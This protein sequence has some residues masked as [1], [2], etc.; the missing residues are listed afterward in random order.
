MHSLQITSDHGTDP[1][2]CLC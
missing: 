1:R 2:N